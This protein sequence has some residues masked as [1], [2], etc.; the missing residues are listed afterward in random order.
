MNQGD[1]LSR[2][3]IGFISFGFNTPKLALA[4]VGR[5]GPPYLQKYPAG[6]KRQSTKSRACSEDALF[7]SV[8]LRRLSQILSLLVPSLLVLVAAD[9]RAAI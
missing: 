4:L 8:I 2:L 1:G 6:A 3:Q 7:L 9:P 5:T